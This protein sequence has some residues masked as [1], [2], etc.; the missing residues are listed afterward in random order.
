MHGIAALIFFRTTKTLGFRP[1]L[2]QKKPQKVFDSDV[3]SAI[4]DAEIE[5]AGANP[6]QNPKAVRSF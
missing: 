3:G 2:S 1:Y 4:L 6:E 5:H